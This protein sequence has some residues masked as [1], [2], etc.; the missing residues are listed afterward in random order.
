MT[1]VAL[2]G[3]V[4]PR[5]FLPELLNTTSGSE[6]DDK[7]TIMIGHESSRG[8]FMSF[9]ICVLFFFEWTDAPHFFLTLR[10]PLPWFTH[11]DTRLETNLFSDRDPAFNFTSIIESFSCTCQNK[12]QQNNFLYFVFLF[13]KPEGKLIFT[14]GTLSGVFDINTLSMKCSGLVPGQYLIVTFTAGHQ[15][16]TI[17]TNF[18]KSP[19]LTFT[20]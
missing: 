3:K 14:P 9:T 20:V 7:T 16:I 17:H 1:T 18:I 15:S 6:S 4:I 8:T 12:K 10:Q 5:N 13:P 19:V 2:P 11:F